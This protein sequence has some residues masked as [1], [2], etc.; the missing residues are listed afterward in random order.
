MRFQWLLP[1][2]ILLVLPLCLA[3]DEEVI[4]DEWHPYIDFFTVDNDNYQV[5]I[6][7]MP[8]GDKMLVKTK[9]ER[10]QASHLI[11]ATAQFDEEVSAYVFEKEVCATEGALRYCLVNLSLEPEN[12]A[13]N[14]EFGQYRYGTRIIIYEE[15]RE[16]ADLEITR[17]IQDNT[18]FVD[19]E[20]KVR[21]SIINTGEVAAE[22]VNYF[23]TIDEELDITRIDGYANRVGT[24]LTAPLVL[25]LHPEEELLYSY[26]VK[27]SSYNN[28]TTLKSTVSFDD[29]D[30]PVELI[31]EDEVSVTWPYKY[32]LGLSDKEAKINEERRLTI[33]IE[34]QEDK[35]LD[36]TI[37][38]TTP[39]NIDETII[40]NY[41][42]IVTTRHECAVSIPVGGTKSCIID[43]SSRYADVYTLEAQTLIEVNEK[44][45]SFSDDVEFT[46]KYDKVTPS[47][48]L[49]K[50]K[51]R[52]GEPITIGVYLHNEDTTLPFLDIQGQLNTSFI[53]E[54]FSLDKIMPDKHENVIF[55]TYNP[56][57]TD[58]PITHQIQVHGTF[59]T[60]NGEKNDFSI[61]KELIVLP[62]NQSV[63]LTQNIEP[64]ELVRGDEVTVTISVENVAD[65][66]YKAVTLKDSYDADLEKTFGETL[67]N[68]HLFG[69]ETKQLYIYKLRVPFSYDKATFDITTNMI[70][71]GEPVQ[72]ET[73]TI[74]VT[75]PVDPSTIPDDTT[76]NKDNT[77][78]D[79]G[80]DT[81]VD[82]GDDTTV[83][84][85]DDTTDTTQTITEKVENKGFFFKIADGIAK[86]FDKIF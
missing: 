33:T 25:K 42:R 53:D 65:S 14:D 54:D 31:D 7:Q 86:F 18:L 80:D 62:E 51:M 70:T 27:P 21:V 64:K 41:E 68:V 44:E 79:D 56:P 28:K 34:N 3:A 17:T 40:E 84:E 23:E 43:V 4:H 73:T 67:G 69:G 47:L 26:W 8:S 38:L 12:E 30:E 46:V 10:N 50:E 22:N 75:D 58:K 32:T 57:Q 72:E 11:T 49:S 13:R 85:G 66:G 35:T 6:V 78:V 77:I 61:T 2:F 29:P 48:I 16:T 83:D 24:K 5:T 74:T 52:S 37:I 63:F 9:F 36:A 45:F 82:D 39:K 71:A 55:K 1:L 81:T 59:K 76:D 15:Q 60:Q 19:E 20:T